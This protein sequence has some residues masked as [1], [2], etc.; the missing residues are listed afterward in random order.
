MEWS[1]EGPG[2]PPAC[3]SASAAVETLESKRRR[4]CRRVRARARARERVSAAVD[5]LLGFDV[6]CE[7]LA[8]Y[9]VFPR[10]RDVCRRWR[11]LVCSEECYMHVVRG[12]GSPTPVPARGERTGGSRVAPAAAPWRAAWERTFHH[13]QWRKRPD[14]FM[15]D[16]PVSVIG[17][18]AND[19]A[20]LSQIYYTYPR[21][22]LQFRRKFSLFGVQACED[23]HRIALKKGVHLRSEPLLEEAEYLCTGR[24]D[25]RIIKLDFAS[26]ENGDTEVVVWTDVAIELFTYP[27]S[28]TGAAPRFNQSLN[29][30]ERRAAYALNPLVSHAHL[31]LGPDSD[32][33]GD[34]QHSLSQ[35]LVLHINEKGIVSIL[36]A[37]GVILQYSFR[38]GQRVHP[39]AVVPGPI[40]NATSSSSSA[41]AASLPPGWLPPAAPVGGRL[42]WKSRERF[43]FKGS[44]AIGAVI[45]DRGAVHI[46]HTSTRSWLT[47][48]PLHMARHAASGGRGPAPRPRYVRTAGCY[49]VFWNG[50]PS[51]CG[52]SGPAGATAAAAGEAAAAGPPFYVEAW[53]CTEVRGVLR[54][55]R[56]MCECYSA[57]SSVHVD[58]SRVYVSASVDRRD[59]FI[60]VWS[61]STGTFVSRIH[62]VNN[63]WSLEKAHLRTHLS[64]LFY[65]SPDAVIYYELNTN[66][67]GSDTLC[68]RQLSSVPRQAY[69]VCRH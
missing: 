24:A 57:S 58:D 51:G 40:N 67:D 23:L 7:V 1:S 55:T 17:S 64:K 49:V 54:G 20:T 16:F 19:E 69:W 8:Y 10:L 59:V 12:L 56:V 28:L 46:L 33:G 62:A 65:S 66:Q 32:A 29:Q 9:G 15:V 60:D 27:G 22:G 52:G 14:T 18:L 6:M 11:L 21:V 38:T 2:A 68:I 3:S 13:V 53:K 39:P 45:D 61:L 50:A 36:M 5:V 25:G 43:E 31:A 37:S 48:E 4:V 63:S 44:A 26:A 42:G 41:A 30:Q 34:A 47:V 35:V